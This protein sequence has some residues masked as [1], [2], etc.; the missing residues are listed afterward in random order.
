MRGVD[1]CPRLDNRKDLGRRHICQGD[2]VRCAECQDIAFAFDGLSL[3][4]QTRK[5]S[6][7]I[8]R[9]IILLRFL[10]RTVIIDKD[11]GPPVLIS[12]ADVVSQCCRVRIAVRESRQAE[13]EQLS[14]LCTVWATIGLTK[15][16]PHFKRILLDSNATHTGYS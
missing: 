12:P 10:H 14:E 9:Q 8:G 7:L 11:E 4:Q 13:N 15:V 1:F 16:C 5:A 3:Q 6:W 2:V